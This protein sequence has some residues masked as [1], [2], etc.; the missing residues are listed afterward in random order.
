MHIAAA[1]DQTC[2]AAIKATLASEIQRCLNADKNSNVVIAVAEETLKQCH[3][4]QFLALLKACV[5]VCPDRVPTDSELC[6][7]FCLLDKEYNFK[8][9]KAKTLKMRQFWAQSEVF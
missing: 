4:T 6:G 5:E 3:L 2:L 9:S 7:A 8:L 1:M